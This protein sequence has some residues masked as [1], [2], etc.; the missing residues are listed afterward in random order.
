MTT[1]RLTFRMAAESCRK[2][3]LYFQITHQ[4]TV[5]AINSRC[6]IFAEEWDEPNSRIFIISPVSAERTATLHAIRN[7]V[8]HEMQ[9]LNSIIS[10]YDSTGLPYAT[11]DIVNCY[12]HT[13]SCLDNSV[14]TFMH[15][16]ISV[17][18]QQSRMRTADTYRQTLNSL[19]SFRNGADICFSMLSATF[20]ESYESWLRSHRLCRNTTSF[21]MRILRSVYNKAVTE[22]L[23]PKGEPFATVYTGVD[24]TSRRAISLADISRIKALNLAADKAMAFARDMFLFSF[25]MRG[26]SFVDMAYLRKKD[27]SNNYVVYSRKKTGQQLTVR[28]EQHM[29]TIVDAYGPSSTQYLLPVIVREDGTERSQ[30]LNAMLRVNR[31]LKKVG[32]LAGISTPLTMY[33][34]RHSWAT[35]AK[36]KDISIGI[37]SEAMGHDS[38]NTTQIYLASIKTNK[39]DDANRDILNGL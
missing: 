29:Q 25:Y 6:Q 2:G 26:M 35:A 9:R 22:G 38:E 13:P 30:Y 32:A 7:R 28:W 10:K 19:M 33:V 4:N 17:L 37:I 39:I 21:Y 18:R 5:K 31:N 24:K 27:L 1:V 11:S 14:F 16:H 3:T 23:A 15:R 20:I 12:C 8:R 36:E 34:A